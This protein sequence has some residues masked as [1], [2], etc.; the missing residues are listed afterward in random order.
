MHDHHDGT[1]REIPDFRTD[2]WLIF[3]LAILCSLLMEQAGKAF[4]DGTRFIVLNYYLQSCP[5]FSSVFQIYMLCSSNICSSSKYSWFPALVPPMFVTVI[6]TS[7]SHIPIWSLHE[8]C[9][10]PPNDYLFKIPDDVYYLNQKN[11]M[12]FFSK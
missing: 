5:A 4:S 2:E 10:F 6:F 7:F 9:F 12:S 3:L 1:A 8:M 11:K